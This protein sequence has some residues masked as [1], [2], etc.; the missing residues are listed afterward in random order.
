MKQR[1]IYTAT[2]GYFL[3]YTAEFLL[4]AKRLM[5]KVVSDVLS[6]AYTEQEDRVAKEEE[7]EEEAMP[8]PW[9]KNL[10]HREK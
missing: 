3:L 4:S 1:P 2:Q 5:L 8:K 7:E 9:G 10:P 6:S